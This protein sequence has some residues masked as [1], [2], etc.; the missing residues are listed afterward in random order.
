MFKKLNEEFDRARKTT[1]ISSDFIIRLR[2]EHR[3][4]CKLLHTADS[5]L[6]VMTGLGI[7]IYVLLLCL[8]VYQLLWKVTSPLLIGIYTFWTVGSLA[9]L[10]FISIGGAL[11]NHAVSIKEYVY[12]PKHKT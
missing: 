12:L 1:D 3:T 2:K 10:G 9:M 4:I 5:N 7:A 8:L 6:H 11:V